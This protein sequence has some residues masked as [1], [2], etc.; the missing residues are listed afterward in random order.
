[1]GF[2]FTA[3]VKD[4]DAT[5]RHAFDWTAWL[6][7][8]EMITAQDVFVSSPGLTIDQVSQDQGVVSY[9]IADG[10]LGAEYIVTCRVTTSQGRIDDRSVQYRVAQR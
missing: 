6:A 1:M 10:D 4:P 8:G 3:P 2:E 7:D 5:L 9:R